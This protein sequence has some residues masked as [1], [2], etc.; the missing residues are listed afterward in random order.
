MQVKS[1]ALTDIGHVRK[2]NQDNYLINEDLL[3]YIVADGMGGMEKGG[4]A[5]Q[6]A[7]NAVNEY[8]LRKSAE[9][10]K[11]PE[12]L[13]TQALEAAGAG[14][15]EAV[16]G[17]SGS[18]I[19]VAMLTGNQAVVANLGD[20]PAYLLRGDELSLLTREHNL[21]GLLV[22]E[23]RLDPVKA[24]DHPYRHQLTAFVGMKGHLP[25][26]V[27]E[28]KPAAG[29]RLLLCSDGLTGMVAEEE[30]LAL[31]KAE[32]V[33]NQAARQLIQ[34]ANEAG[35]YDNITVLLVDIL[36]TEK[37]SENIAQEEK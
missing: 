6:Y 30:I 32:S 9:G 4:A 31:L 26:H 10:Q 21:A 1:F 14:F 7:V 23:G 12:E 18:T 5:A 25:V 33:L 8:V 24:K 13:I 15:S 27:A 19:V 16:G 20:S 17:D 35:G 22:E 28:F 29:D 2:E 3:L 11:N 37:D 34:M 36:S